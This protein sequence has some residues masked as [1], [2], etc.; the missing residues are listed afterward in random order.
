MNNLAK[1]RFK[2]EVDPDDDDDDDEGGGVT[3][4]LED[5]QAAL[6]SSGIK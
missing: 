6:G 1:G 3:A 2:T 4:L 5:V